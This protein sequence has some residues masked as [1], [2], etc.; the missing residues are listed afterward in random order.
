MR[1]AHKHRI[2]VSVRTLTQKYIHIQTHIRTPT[3]ERRRQRRRRQVRVFSTSTAAESD[4]HRQL[5]RRTIVAHTLV[6]DGVHR[7]GRGQE[8]PAS[9]QK[10]GQGSRCEY[11]VQ[12][13][14][15]LGGGRGAGAVS[16]HVD[17]VQ[18][19]GRS[20]RAKQNV[21][22][23]LANTHTRARARIHGSSYVIG[24]RAYTRGLLCVCVCWFRGIFECSM[25]QICVCDWIFLLLLQ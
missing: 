4:T 12:C 15:L 18:N 21:R 7:S 20:I 6:Q 23:T 24:V 16:A 5:D 9:F 22:N 3:N 14:G 13:G 17:D 11:W 1:A 10:Q 2:E 8:S 19:N 25:D